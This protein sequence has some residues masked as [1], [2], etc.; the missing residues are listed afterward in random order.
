M[1]AFYALVVWAIGNAVK[2]FCRG[3]RYGVA[4]D[5]MPDTRDVVDLLEGVY[6]ARR[7]CDFPQETLLHETVVRLYRSAESL[8]RLTGYH[9]V[10]NE[11]E[12]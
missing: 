6:I 12:E 10:R 11:W 9:L 3:T 2:S 7:E 5:E 4:I 1:L 8:T